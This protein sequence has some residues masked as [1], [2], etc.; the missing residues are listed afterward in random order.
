MVT[1]SHQDSATSGIG[2]KAE[3]A[4]VAVGAGMES[5]GET[6]REHSPKEGILG[7]ASYA[8]SDRLESGGHYLEEKG[9]KGIGEDVTNMIR[10][11]PVP[12]LLV[13]IGLGFLLA[14]IMRS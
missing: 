10:S 7:N 2:G 9:L 1:V 3:Y 4:A 8:V 14:K 6:I 13:G 5:L 11:N 12:A